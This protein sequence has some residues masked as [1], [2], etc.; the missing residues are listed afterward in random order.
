MKTLPS[1]SRTKL[2]AAS[3]MAIGRCRGYALALDSLRVLV[4]Q[5]FGRTWSR[6]L[7]VD[8][9]VVQRVVAGGHCHNLPLGGPLRR[10]NRRLWA[11]SYL[12][13][14]QSVSITELVRSSLLCGSARPALGCSGGRHKDVELVTDT[15]QI[16][17]ACRARDAALRQSQPWADYLQDNHPEITS[18]LSAGSTLER[19]C[20]ER[21]RIDHAAARP[22]GATAA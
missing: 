21:A 22:A 16:V 1:R 3:A 6:Q 4:G 8:V 11:V 20:C 13:D 14:S 10:P 9:R 2:P 19:N 18:Y 12:R 5:E 15:G 17:K 7:T